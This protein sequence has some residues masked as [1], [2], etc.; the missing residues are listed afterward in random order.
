MVYAAF[1]ILM[2]IFPRQILQMF[3]SGKMQVGRDVAAV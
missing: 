1:K 3:A 2:K